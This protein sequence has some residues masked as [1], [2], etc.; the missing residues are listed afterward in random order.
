MKPIIDTQQFLALSSFLNYQLAGEPINWQGLMN[1]LVDKPLDEVS[2]NFL[3]EVL[4]L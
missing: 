4:L 2:K 3:M 1:L